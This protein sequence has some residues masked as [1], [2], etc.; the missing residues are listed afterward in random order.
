M[1]RRILRTARTART[2]LKANVEDA[3]RVRLFGTAPNTAEPT[4]DL[5]PQELE[6]AIDNTIA[7][8]RS[9]DREKS[10]L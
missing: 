2:P 1:T 7:E 6:L 10:K 3:L 4:A 8:F 9:R 5:F